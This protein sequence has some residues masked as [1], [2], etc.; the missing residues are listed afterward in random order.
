MAGR[1]ARALAPLAPGSNVAVATSASAAPRV[2]MAATGVGPAGLLDP[3][4]N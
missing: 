1:F 4:A 3:T 2:A